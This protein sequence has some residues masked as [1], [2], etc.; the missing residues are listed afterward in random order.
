MLALGL[1]DDTV[2]LPADGLPTMICTGSA[3]VCRNSM[4]H[5]TSSHPRG[6]SFMRLVPC[7]SS[8]VCLWAHHAD[9]CE[10][11]HAACFLLYPAASNDALHLLLTVGSAQPEA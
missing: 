5:Q 9:A 2:D 3:C 11:A 4:C 8:G 1:G 10:A 7:F 6:I